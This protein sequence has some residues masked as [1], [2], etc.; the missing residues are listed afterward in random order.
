[1][2]TC[3]PLKSLPYLWSGRLNA[4]SHRQPAKLVCCSKHSAAWQNKTPVRTEIICLCDLAI[5]I[6]E[7]SLF[8][9]I[10]H[11]SEFDGHRWCLPRNVSTRWLHSDN[12]AAAGQQCDRVITAASNLD[13]LFVVQKLWKADGTTMHTHSFFLKGRWARCLITVLTLLSSDPSPLCV[14]VGANDERVAVWF[15]EG[16]HI[17]PRRQVCD[18]I[19]EV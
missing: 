8:Q 18:V 19:P 14:H 12:L 7:V 11:L 2:S 16:Q 4:G 13:L 1:M 5:S 3:F 9:N 15:G 6:V 10:W 17:V